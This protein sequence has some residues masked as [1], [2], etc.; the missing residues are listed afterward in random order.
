MSTNWRLAISTSAISSEYEADQENY[1]ELK[2]NVG[3]SIP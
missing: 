2:T 3:K 1:G